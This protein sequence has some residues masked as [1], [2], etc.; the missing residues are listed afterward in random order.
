[1]NKRQQHPARADALVSQDEA[2]SSFNFEEF[3]MKLEASIQQLEGR[4]R[5]I[6]R[7]TLWGLGIFLF[8]V[9]SVP[10]MQV[11]ELAV[12]HWVRLVWGITGV[13]AMLTTGVLAAIYQYRYA[14]A[15][16][17]ARSDLTSTMIA[18]LQQQVADLSRKVNSK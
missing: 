16:T 2:V 13:V 6:R 18:E 7:A 9:V 11:S 3:R 12:H 8:C 15:L 5:T 10:M 1:M 4:A 14:P 17:R